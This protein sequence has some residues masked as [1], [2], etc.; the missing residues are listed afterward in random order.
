MLRQDQEVKAKSASAH[1]DVVGDGDTT[2][3]PDD[4]ES[5]EEGDDG[6]NG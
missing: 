6:F 4:D 3:Q 2:N 1:G 5:E